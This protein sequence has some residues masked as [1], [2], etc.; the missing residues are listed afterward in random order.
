[1][2]LP[3]D[4]LPKNRVVLIRFKAY[5]GAYD[6]NLGGTIAVEIKCVGGGKNGLPHKY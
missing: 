6:S 1:M 4:Y 5:L 2:K 3:R